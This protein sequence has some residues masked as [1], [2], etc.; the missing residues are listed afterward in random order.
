MTGKRDV[1]DRDVHAH[2]QQAHA[3]DGKHQ[4]GVRGG[5]CRRGL[6][7][8]MASAFIDARL[9]LEVPSLATPLPEGLG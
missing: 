7:R 6:V 1:D 4:I 9:W 2:Q 8:S 3:A 5:F